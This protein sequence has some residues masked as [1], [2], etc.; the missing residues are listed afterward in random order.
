MPLENGI[1]SKE[2]DD[3]GL[4]VESGAPEILVV[5]CRSND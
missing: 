2:C 4:T 1:E 5:D 3:L